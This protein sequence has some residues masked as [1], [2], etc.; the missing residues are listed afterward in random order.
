VVAFRAHPLPPDTDN[1]VHA[2]VVRSIATDHDVV[3]T[4]PLPAV[5]SATARERVAFEATAAEVAGLGGMRPEAAML[6]LVLLCVVLLPLSLAMLMLETTGSWVMAAVAPLLGIG[7]TMIPWA[8][9]YGEF[10]YLA[11]ATLVVPLALAARRALLDNQRARN[12]LLVAACVTAIW[13]THGLE[14][15]TAVVIGVPFALASL[16]GRD[17]RRL[18]TGAVGVAAAVGAGALLVTLLTPHVAVPAVAPPEGVVSST[19]AMQMLARMGSRSQMLNALA[20]FVHSE[21][22]VPAVLLYVLGIAAS[23]LVR[24]VRWLLVAHV[25][26]LVVLADVGYGGILMRLWTPVFPW[27]GADRIVSIQWFIVP[28]LMTWGVFSAPMV[29]RPVIARMRTPRAVMAVMGSVAAVAL[30]CVVVSTWRSLTDMQSSA[31]GSSHTGDADVVALAAMDRA[32]PPGTLVLANT[33]ADAGQWIDVLT[34][35]VEWAPL[36]FTRNFV[37]AG[38]IRPATDPKVDAVARACDDPRTARV[39]L[40]GI[41]AVFVGSLPDT[42]AALRW[43]AACIARLPGVHEV[44]HATVDGHTASVF[45]V[46]TTLQAQTPGR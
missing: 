44:T 14:F 30:L 10:P 5:G 29:F 7:F 12:L 43:D 1:P 11:D 20:D 32:L 41:G 34:R 27:S 42:K 38:S 33:G 2:A 40:N 19:Q 28:L 39:A 35:D 23:L 16:R 45:S 18:A 46:D 37:Q 4:Q 26:L 21:L 17:L 15:L 3:T 31:T 13:V 25:L 8:L 36:A 6:P 9:E 24:G 22:V